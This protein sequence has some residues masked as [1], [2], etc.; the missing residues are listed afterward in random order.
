MTKTLGEFPRQLKPFV[1]LLRLGKKQAKNGIHDYLHEREWRCAKDIDFDGLK[2]YAVVIP[3]RR[4]K[5]KN[6]LSIVNAARE[7][8][9]LF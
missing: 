4:P 6:E 2:P 9:E 8:Q 5:A 1:N 7:F 3:R